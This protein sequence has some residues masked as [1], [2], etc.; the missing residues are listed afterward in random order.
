MG[1]K[2][3]SEFPIDGLG[4][5]GKSGGTEYTAEAFLAENEIMFRKNSVEKCQK[6]TSVVVI[7]NFDSSTL[8]LF[9][10]VNLDRVDVKTE[11]FL[12]QAVHVNVDFTSPFCCFDFLLC[13]K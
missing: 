3:S 8:Q 10:I 2:G 5:Q 6:F 12:A 11:R 9:N 4:W 13:R 1:I 7:S